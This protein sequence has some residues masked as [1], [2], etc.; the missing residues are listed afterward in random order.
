MKL[1]SLVK[2]IYMNLGLVVEFISDLIKLAF[3]SR[4]F[5]KR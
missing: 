2:F 5:T 4:L 3:V 1:I